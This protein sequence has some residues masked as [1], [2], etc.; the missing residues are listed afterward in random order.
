MSQKLFLLDLTVS[1]S[2]L[3]FREGRQNHLVS[4]NLYT[5]LITFSVFK[6]KKKI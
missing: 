6:R 5:K 3:H 4:I 1:Y 2:S